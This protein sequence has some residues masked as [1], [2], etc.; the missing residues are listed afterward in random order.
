MNRKSGTK[1]FSLV[2]LLAVVLVL[3]A[4]AAIAIPLYASQRQ[5]SQAR[6]CIANIAALASSCSA[7]ALRTGQYPTAAILNAGTAWNSATP[8]SGGIIGAPEG[9]AVNPVCPSNSAVYVFTGGGP[10]AT[11][12]IAC[13]NSATHGTYGPTGA[14]YS[15]TLPI[16]GTDSLP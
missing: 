8:T 1:G 10:A 7:Y 3:S 2:E 16:P 9:I 13:P 6:V 15:T 4:L 5:S 12:K 14:T 11:L